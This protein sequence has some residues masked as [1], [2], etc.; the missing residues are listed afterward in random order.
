MPRHARRHADMN[1]AKRAEPID[2]PFGLWIRVGPRKHVLHGGPDPHAKGQFRGK[3]MPVHARR[4][5]AV[6]C[7]KMAEPIDLT[8]VLWTLVCRKKH[9]FNRIRQVA[10]VCHHG[11]ARW[12]HLANTI[13]PSVSDG[14]AVMSNCFE[15]LLLSWSASGLQV[16]YAFVCVNVSRL[17]TYLLTF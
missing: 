13:E 8:F 17:S 7:A 9:K 3:V 11:R 16:A 1:C 5:S 12:L 15:H 2:M 4:Q 14:H 6:S 10:P